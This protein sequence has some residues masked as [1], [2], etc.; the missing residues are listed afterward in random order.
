M[1]GTFHHH[2]AVKAGGHP[3]SL[4]H[5]GDQVDGQVL[6]FAG[7]F[8]LLVSGHIGLHK[9]Q[10]GALVRRRRGNPIHQRDLAERAQS[11]GHET[12]QVA[13]STRDQHPFFAH[14]L[15][16]SSTLHC[17]AASQS[18]LG[19]AVRIEIRRAGRVPALAAVL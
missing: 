18:R 10:V 2:V 5:Q 1:P 3:E 4:A 15:P 19:E 14:D 8:H 16:S 11:S 17:A 9:G 6:V 7:R 13:C 12:C